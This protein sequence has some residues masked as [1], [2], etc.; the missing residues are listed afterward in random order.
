M[1]MRIYIHMFVTMELGQLVSLSVQFF[2][3]KQKSLQKERKILN[4]AKLSI[5]WR[6]KNEI[7]RPLNPTQKIK[8]NLLQTNLKSQNTAFVTDFDF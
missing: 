3:Q 7:K 5:V 8:D 1:I 6:H 4:V 2:S